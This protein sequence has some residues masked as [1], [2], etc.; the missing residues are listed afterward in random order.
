MNCGELR[1]FDK[2]DWMALGGAEKFP[3]GDEP[4]IGTVFLERK[5]L[6]VVV[7]GQGV[8]VYKEDGTGW[9]LLTPLVSA[10]EARILVKALPGPW[11]DQ[12]RKF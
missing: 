3:N 11:A 10:E 2:H 8:G 5:S 9:D 12:W 4:L 7:D 6:C 1:S